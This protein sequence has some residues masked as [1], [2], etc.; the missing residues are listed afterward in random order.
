[1][2]PE[3]IQNVTVKSLTIKFDPEV[4][5]GI[6]FATRLPPLLKEL[7]FVHHVIEINHLT[8][9]KYYPQAIKELV[10]IIPKDK[11]CAVY[12]PHFRGLIL[13]ITFAILDITHVRPII[14]ES[15][16]V[17]EDRRE[18]DFI[19]GKKLSRFAN[20][21]QNYSDKVRKNRVF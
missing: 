9:D 5:F 21:V 15:Y 14:V 7:G 18:Y 19:D 11:R 16:K 12:F 8:S 10:Q 6:C 2:Y 3:Y 17:S 13:P 1:M 4:H 20:S